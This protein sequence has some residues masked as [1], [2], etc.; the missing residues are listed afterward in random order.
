MNKYGVGKLITY[1]L[2][3]WLVCKITN[4]ELSTV[5]FYTMDPIC[6][7]FVNMDVEGVQTEL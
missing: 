5:P 2:D 4:S 1:S 3:Y 7:H 6:L